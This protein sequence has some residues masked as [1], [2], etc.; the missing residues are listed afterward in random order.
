MVD[1]LEARKFLSKLR[2]YEI[3]W[4]KLVYEGIF[5][6]ECAFNFLE[7]DILEQM[8]TSLVDIANQCRLQFLKL[9]I[10]Q[11]ALAENIEVKDGEVSIGLDSFKESG[12]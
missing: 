9:R 1:N 6:R 10:L 2:A 8:C 3:V 7:E 4:D 12:S 5:D 11:D